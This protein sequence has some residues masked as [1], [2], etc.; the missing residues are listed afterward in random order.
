MDNP[1]TVSIAGEA[2]EGF[3]H[4]SFP[5]DESMPNMNDEAKAFTNAWREANPDKA[6][7]VNA[8]L[9]Y[10]SYIMILDAITRAG[11]AQSEAITTALGATQNLNTPLGNLTLDADHNPQ[12]PVGII[13]IKNGQRVYLGEVQPK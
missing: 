13:E 7:N 2:A 4:T 10:T 9:G 8:A 1:E 6:P 5:Y 3:I 11:Q 12:M